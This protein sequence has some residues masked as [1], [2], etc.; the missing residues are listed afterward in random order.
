MRTSLLLIQRLCDLNTLPF[1]TKVKN[2][3]MESDGKFIKFMQTLQNEFFTIR[4]D[5]ETLTFSYDCKSTW[6][7]NLKNKVPYPLNQGNMLVNE[8]SVQHK[9]LL[10]GVRELNEGVFKYQQIN[11]YI[12]VKDRLIFI[13]AN[14]EFSKAASLEEE[15]LKMK[16]YKKSIYD[17]K[18]EDKL[19]NDIKMLKMEI[20]PDLRPIVSSVQHKTPHRVVRH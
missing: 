8:D 15:K 14:R 17:K 5:I 1:H 4:F 11:N 16:R 18:T 9:E 6:Y 3:W 7:S 19:N 20:T 10:H 2:E 13:A 12:E